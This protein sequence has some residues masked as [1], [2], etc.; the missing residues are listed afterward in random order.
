MIDF[1]FR[2]L[3]LNFPFARSATCCAQMSMTLPKQV[4]GLLIDIDGTVTEAES[5][6]AGVP[7][8]LEFLR[9]RNV[10]YRLVTNTT[11]KPRSAIVTKM[12]EP[13]FGRF[14]RGHYHRANYWAR[15]SPPAQSYPLLPSVEG[16]PPGRF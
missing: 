7:K 8:A 9:A 11:S 5:L 15:I 13:W 2:S 16:F 6:V 14:T 12:R 1:P 4:R 3:T 10:P